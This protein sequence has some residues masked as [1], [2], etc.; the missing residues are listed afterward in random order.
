M[1]FTLRT[2][3]AS[4]SAAALLSVSAAHAGGYIAP[5]VDVE[6]V[7]VVEA[8]PA[9]WQGGYAGITLGY[10][11]NGDDDIGF[12][13]PGIDVGS[14]ELSGINGG[15][16]LGYRWQRERWVF[17]PEVSYD[18]GDIQDDFTYQ[19]VDF[20][21]SV[22]EMLAVR[23]K[24]GYLV[25]PDMLVYGMAGWQWGKF[26]YTYG[27]VD[28]DYDADGYVLGLGVEKLLTERLSVTGEYE[29]SNFGSTDVDVV[30]GVN[31]VATP[32]YSNV[33]LGLNFRF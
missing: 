33:K 30:P 23:F 31:S 8:A 21:S 13:P 26:N 22:E 28:G 12:N 24:T 18:L 5:V 20:E 6:P 11:F 9:D 14:A 32:E 4:A 16:R 2:F 1:R 10:A 29:Y 17:G 19:G 27:P 25:R 7:P 3:F 15:L